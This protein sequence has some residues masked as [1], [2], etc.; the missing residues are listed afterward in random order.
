MEINAIC[1]WETR[2]TN[3]IFNKIKSNHQ[4]VAFDTGPGNALIDDVTYELFKLNFDKDGAIA[5]K[6][7]ASNQ[8]VDQ[9]I[10]EDAFFKHSPPKSLDRNHFKYVQ[11]TVLAADGLTAEDKIS[12]I[13]QLTVMSIV[14]SLNHES[15]SV[16][17]KT[18]Y[19]C[20]GG[21]LSFLK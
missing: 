15:L 6:G 4:L 10:R 5:F 1:I 18:V 17:P 13:T 3:L 11:D 14:K 8:L 16:R 12:T 20:G 9:I 7:T 19:V 2:S 21:K